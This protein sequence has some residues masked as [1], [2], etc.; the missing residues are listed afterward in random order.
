MSVG[1][2]ANKADWDNRSGSLAVQLRDTFAAIQRFR[3]LLVATPDANLIALG[4]VQAEIDT[5]KSAYLDLDQ[6]AQVYN[7]TAT[8]TP[9]YNYQTF[10]KLITGVV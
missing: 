2:P 4:Y 5:M 1:L 10:A 6:L 7:G 8:R 3:T 9:A